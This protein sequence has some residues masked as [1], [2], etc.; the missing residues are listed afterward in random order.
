[1]EIIVRKPTEEEVAEMR[2]NPVWTC[3]VSEFD[4]HY[5]SEETCL[6]IEGEVTV[7]Y[8]SKS[9]S[10]ASGDY[11]VFP[12]GLSCVWQVKKPVKKHYIFN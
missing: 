8:G 11:V 7:L 6:I 5:D 1:M 2:S 10:F 4:W 3:E 12:K 9:V